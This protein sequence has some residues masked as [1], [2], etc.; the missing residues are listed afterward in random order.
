MNETLGKHYSKIDDVIEILLL[1]PAHTN[2]PMYER[3]RVQ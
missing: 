3:V 1:S 2:P